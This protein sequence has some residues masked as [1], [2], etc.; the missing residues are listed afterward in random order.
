MNDQAAVEILK[1]P[2]V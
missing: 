1:Q 2:A